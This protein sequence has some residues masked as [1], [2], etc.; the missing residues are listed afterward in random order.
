MA[1]APAADRTLVPPGELEE[2]VRGV[3]LK[4]EGISEATAARVARS[5]VAANLAGHDSHGV[6]LLPYWLDLVESGQ[7]RLDAEPRVVD[8]H[9]ALVRL[10]G[11]LGFGP[12]TC[13]LAVELALE[14]APEYGVCCVVAR[15]ANHIGR[16][17]EY[18][19]RLA[20]EGIV[21]LMLVN[22]QGSGQMVPPV[23]GR[24]RRLTNN[25]VSF[26]APGAGGPLL[27]DVA[28]TVVAEAKVWLA[29]A[30]G[31]SVPEGWILDSDGRP[32]TNP[33]DL[34]EGGALLPVGGHKGY[35]LMVLVDVI[36]GILSGGGVCREDAPEH[37]SNAFVLVAID[38]RK[39]VGEGEWKAEAEVLESYVK[40]ATPVS[41]EVPIML[42]GEP[43]LAS[44]AARRASGIPIEASTWATLRELAERPA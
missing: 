37:F 25:P 29:Q 42:P 6:L 44:A 35:A 32:S 26:A 23:G 5:L 17:G 1:D 4:R 21:A 36:A 12:L 38:T 40:S 8:D 30:R 39:L 18:T 7:I 31:E 27:F 9:G 34:F 24:E 19:E 2:L 22:C 15:N 20:N 41:D 16:V 10:D 28:L 3:L 11:G 13:D 43:E 33:D 14:R